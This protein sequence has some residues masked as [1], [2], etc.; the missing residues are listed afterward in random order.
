MPNIASTIAPAIESSK[1]STTAPSTATASTTAPSIPAQVASTRPALTGYMLRLY[2]NEARYEFLKLLRNRAFTLS[3]TGFPVIFYLMFASI[4]AHEQYHGQLY[5]RYLLAGY[6]CF[7]AM[8][9]ALFGIGA[10]LAHERGHGWLELKRASPMPA[11]AYL[12]AKLAASIAFAM[13]ITMLLA[14][15]GTLISGHIISLFELGKLLLVVAAGC[16]PFASVG[17]LLGLIM[18]PNA[19]PG[20]I[21]LF[22]L[23]LSFCGGLWMPVDVLPHWLQHLAHV[24]P[25]Y[26]FSRLALHTFGYS[27]VSPLLSWSVLATYT[28]VLLALCGIVFRHSEARA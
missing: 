9:S 11:G 15:L 25:S 6:A 18:A 5:S 16:I 7:G 8:G 23:P 20:I 27:A 28:L 3:T 10:G 13:V 2:A 4:N 22:Y 24:L 14:L 26:Y 21:N 19:A 12:L 1:A 17:L